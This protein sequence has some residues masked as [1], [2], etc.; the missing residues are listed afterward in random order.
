MF[1]L[2]RTMCE[3]CGAI[4]P[5]LD[6]VEAYKNYIRANKTHRGEKCTNL[7]YISKK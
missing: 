5:A 6:T 4:W 1:N 7:V 3:K 2:N